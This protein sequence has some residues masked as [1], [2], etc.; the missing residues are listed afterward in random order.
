VQV[1]EENEEKKPI[2]IWARRRDMT[3]INLRIGYI[4]GMAIVHRTNKVII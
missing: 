2:Y 4:D 1:C 3:G